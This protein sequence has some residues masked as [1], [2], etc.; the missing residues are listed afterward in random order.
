MIVQVDCAKCG[1]TLEVE[2]D[3]PE[4]KTIDAIQEYDA[5]LDDN[6]RNCIAF[7]ATVDV[8][9]EYVELI[10]IVLGTYKS[11]GNG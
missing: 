4:R 3:I 1:E 8:Y 6:V 2:I 7:T 5:I 9:R 10:R 11:A